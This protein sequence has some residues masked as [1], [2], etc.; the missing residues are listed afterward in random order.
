ML[1]G[2]FCGIGRRYLRRGLVGFVGGRGEG[3]T[4]EET[5]GTDND[6][7]PEWVS[8]FEER[9]AIPDCSEVGESVFGRVPPFFLFVFAAGGA[10]G[11]RREARGGA[12]EQTHCSKIEWGCGGLIKGSGERDWMGVGSG[13]VRWW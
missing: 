1:G 3:L 10:G 2:Q 7:T 8:V 13:E 9:V 11:L 4:E 5:G 6:G 12:V